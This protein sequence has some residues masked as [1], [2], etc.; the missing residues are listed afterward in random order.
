MFLLTFH[1]NN[2]YFER[3]CLLFIRIIGIFNVLAWFI[4]KTYE[5][6][7][8]PV[9]PELP[10][11]PSAS[12]AF[13]SLPQPPRA[14]QTS[15]SIPEPPSASKASHSL[16]WPDPPVAPNDWF[17]GFLKVLLGFIGF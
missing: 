1:Q 14:S 15:R 8:I 12:K 5:I 6:L 13:H 2:W 4:V 17:I 10:E 9:I 16:P 7:M 3:F 11:L